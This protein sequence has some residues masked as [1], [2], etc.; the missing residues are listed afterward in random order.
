MNKDITNSE[1]GYTYEEVVK[2]LQPN[3]ALLQAEYTTNWRNT[4]D[5]GDVVISPE[6]RR[7]KQDREELV[8]QMVEAAFL[9][10]SSYK[11]H[12]AIVKITKLIEQEREKL[13]K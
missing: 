5:T 13:K 8:R 2:E 6:L 7:L 4:Y 12:N 9:K 10:M 1:F 3:E 11:I